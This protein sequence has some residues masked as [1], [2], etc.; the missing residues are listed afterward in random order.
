MKLENLALKN[1]HNK[2]IYITEHKKKRFRINQI[3]SKRFAH[4]MRE[5]CQVYARHCI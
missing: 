4:E 2:A 3:M 5:R 1:G